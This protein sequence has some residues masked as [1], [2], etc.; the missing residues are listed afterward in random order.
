MRGSFYSVLRGTFDVYVSMAGGE[1]NLVC[2]D[3]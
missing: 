1:P 3:K 2:V